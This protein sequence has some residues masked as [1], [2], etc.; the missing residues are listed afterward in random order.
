MT[1]QAAVV[2]RTHGIQH[3]GLSVSDLQGAA[4]F[5]CDML[6]FRVVGG[7]PS[8][9]AMFVSDGRSTIT[10]WQVKDPETCSAFDRHQN[11]GL[12]HLALEVDSRAALDALHADMVAYGTDIEF[13]PESRND[14]T[15]QHMMLNIPGGPRLELIALNRA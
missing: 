12:H 10:L 4:D 1:E 2:P 8:H 13:A 7:R 5:F 14:G 6:G 3:V 15:A 9:P 11:E